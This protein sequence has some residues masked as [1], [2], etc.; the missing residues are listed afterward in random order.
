MKTYLAVRQ[1]RAN[2]VRRLGT[3]WAALVEEVQAELAEQERTAAAHPRDGEA[4]PSL[5]IKGNRTSHGE[6]IYHVPGGQFYD[7]VHAEATFAT[8]E[9]AQA[10]GYRP[11]AR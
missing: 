6:L 7:V 1:R 11:S 8:E 10:A 3:S 2:P 4:L 9:L 5:P